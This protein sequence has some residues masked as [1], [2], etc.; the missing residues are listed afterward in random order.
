MFQ[1]KKWKNRKSC[2]ISTFLAAI[3]WRKKSFC[4]YFYIPANWIRLHKNAHR[5]REALTVAVTR[6]LHD[7][8][9]EWF[10]EI[11]ELRAA[12]WF[13]RYWAG[14]LGNYTNATAG[15]VGFNKASGIK[16]DWRYMLRSTI[17]DSRTNKRM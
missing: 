7:E 16:G 4:K 9:I 15:Y 2:Q 8:M 11:N 6:L 13:K 3:A 12:A 17:G 1:N 10:N 5:L 14:E